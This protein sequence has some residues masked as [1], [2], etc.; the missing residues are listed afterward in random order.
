MKL[1]DLSANDVGGRL[2]LFIIRPN[3]S[4]LPPSFR[5]NGSPGLCGFKVLLRIEFIC[6]TERAFMQEQDHILGRTC[7]PALISSPDS[8][9]FAQLPLLSCNVFLTR[10]MSDADDKQVQ[11]CDY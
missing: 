3:C 8:E 9:S 4:P 6:R 5:F 7:L 2:A 10:V 11:P 1:I